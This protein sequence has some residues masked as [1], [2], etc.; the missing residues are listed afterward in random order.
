MAKGI[1]V[2]NHRTEHVVTHCRPFVCAIV[3]P[4]STVAADMFYPPTIPHS[5]SY[6]ATQEGRT[7][8]QAW[9]DGG[10][11]GKA[12]RVTGGGVASSPPSRPPSTPRSAHPHT[13]RHRETVRGGGHERP[14]GRGAQPNLVER[15][16]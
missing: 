5:I 3:S 2:P 6:S 4:A 12:P 11:D 16:V 13:P 1:Y 15:G 14:P 10:R 8:G 9:G 7:G